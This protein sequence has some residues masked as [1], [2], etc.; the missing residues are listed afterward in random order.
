MAGV[1]DAALDGDQAV[2]IDE[3]FEVMDRIHDL[4]L[5]AGGLDHF[6]IAVDG[7]QGRQAFLGCVALPEL[8]IPRL[9]VFV[10]ASAVG[11]HSLSTQSASFFQGRQSNPHFF[12]YFC[13]SGQDS[14]HPPDFTRR[15]RR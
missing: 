13:S 9:G 11:D 8:E 15:S 12:Q 6:H 5:P 2:E 10:G 3:I 4:P 1:I 14:A 7:N